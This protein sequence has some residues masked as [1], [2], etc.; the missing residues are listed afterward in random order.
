MSEMILCETPAREASVRNKRRTAPLEPGDSDSD[1]PVAEMRT[2]QT[3]KLEKLDK[4][5]CQRQAES[6]TQQMKPETK[7]PSKSDSDEDDSSSI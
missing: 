6:P 2:R 3:V 7:A 5:Q 1:T 4:E